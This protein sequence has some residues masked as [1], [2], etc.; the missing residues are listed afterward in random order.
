MGKAFSFAAVRAKTHV[1]PRPDI[2]PLLHEACVLGMKEEPPS[3]GN[4]PL[5]QPRSR[6]ASGLPEPMF[7]DP[8]GNCEGFLS[9]PIPPFKIKLVQVGGYNLNIKHRLSKY[10]CKMGTEGQK[11]IIFSQLEDSSWRE[12]NCSRQG[13]YLWA[14]RSSRSLH[15]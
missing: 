11:R 13:S 8:G 15:L 14:W 6:S 7:I 4:A 3:R 5:L 9:L 12:E 10:P 1:F 2:P